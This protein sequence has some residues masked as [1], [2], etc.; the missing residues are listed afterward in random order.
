MDDRSS[1][2]EEIPIIVEADITHARA[3]VAKFEAQVA[4]GPHPKDP[5]GLYARTRLAGWQKELARLEQGRIY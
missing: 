4:A 3:M 1:E 5:D 2:L